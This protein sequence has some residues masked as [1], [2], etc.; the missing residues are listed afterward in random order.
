LTWETSHVFGLLKEVVCTVGG[1]GCVSAKDTEERDCRPT[2][3]LIVV[4][5]TSWWENVL[6]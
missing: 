6:L 4:T 5:H 3:I 1:Y 2:D